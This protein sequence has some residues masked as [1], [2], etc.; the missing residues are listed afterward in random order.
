MIE[1]QLAVFRSINHSG[2]IIFAII[3]VL[4]P[5]R[6]TPFGPIYENKWRSKGDVGSMPNR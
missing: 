2:P 4:L 3:G 6:V 5:V 1:D